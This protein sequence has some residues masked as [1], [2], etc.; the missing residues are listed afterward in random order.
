[1]VLSAVEGGTM[2][3]VMMSGQSCSS[4]LVVS[5]DGQ[6]GGGYRGKWLSFGV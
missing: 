4:V 2:E 5:D 6:E 3:S 1:M